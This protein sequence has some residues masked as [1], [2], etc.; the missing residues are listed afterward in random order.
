MRDEM[1]R[2]IHVHIAH[3][4]DLAGI[5]ET[6]FNLDVGQGSIPGQIDLAFD[7]SFN[8]GVI[9][10]IEHP[11]KIDTVLAEVRLES[12]EDT[13]IGRGC[14]PTKPHHKSLLLGKNVHDGS[15]EIQTR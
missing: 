1:R 6:T 2:E 13:D 14:C 11:V 4:D 5:L 8:E 9:V 12:A 7:K 3:G 15:T 10:R